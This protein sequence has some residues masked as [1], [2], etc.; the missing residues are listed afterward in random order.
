MDR[1]KVAIIGCGGY[2][3]AHARRLSARPDVEIVALASR[4]ASSIDRLVERRLSTYEP[5][6]EH[7]TSLDELYANEALDAVI[8]STPHHLH[9]EQAMQA[10]ESGCHVL[11]EKPMVT[12]LEEARRLVER[13]RQERRSGR[14]LH[15]GVCYNPA[16]SPAMEHVRDAVA[17]GS[18]GR[19]ELVT[20]YLSQDWKRLTAGSW[21]QVPDESGGGQAMD[22]G[23]HLIHSLLSTAGA[24]AAELFAWSSTLRTPV[25]VNTIVSVRFENGV[26]ATLTI[27][28]DSPVD[29]TLMSLIFDG[30]RIDVD[31]W[32][33]EWVRSFRPDTEPCVLEG[34]S[35]PSPDD[36]FIDAVLGKGE[37]IVSEQ[38][39]L[40]VAAF[41]DALYRSI[42][43]GAPT[44]VAPLEDGV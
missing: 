18:H 25:D 22:S 17:T 40:R 4:S 26:L 8:I 36:N 14:K 33:G 23:A 16:F 27:G 24:P 32:R 41:M 21:R 35:E 30:G 12:S 1:A 6:P 31:G 29:G 11:I 43:S 15:L 20:A 7:Y 5:P 2:A 3:G 44:R 42:D 9:F 10:I 13:A 34:L 28:G 38:D 19:L 37:L 39:G